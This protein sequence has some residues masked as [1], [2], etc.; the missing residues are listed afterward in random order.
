MR[1]GRRRPGAC[2]SAFVLFQASLPEAL[3]KETMMEVMHERVAGL[4][5]H[6]D[7]IVA[8]V[9]LMSGGK[10]KREC[11]TFDTTTAG[12]EA[13]AGLAHVLAMRS[14][15]DGGYRG[16]LDAGLEDTA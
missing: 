12:L 5:V 11:R 9:R 14:G 13:P 16:L 7:N 10:A 6:K 2:L 1:Q 4:D 3:V 8:C 15:R